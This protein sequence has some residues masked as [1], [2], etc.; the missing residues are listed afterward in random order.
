MLHW[1][2]VKD[3][4]INLIVMAIAL[5]SIINCEPLKNFGV[6]EGTSF[7]HVMFKAYQYATIDKN[8][9]AKLQHVKCEGCPS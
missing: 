2:I 4:G 1:V 5:H 8:V 6:Y 7:G 9:F 3:E